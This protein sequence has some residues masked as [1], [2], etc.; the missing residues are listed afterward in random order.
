MGKPRRPVSR[1]IRKVSPLNGRRPRFLRGYEEPEVQRSTIQCTNSSVFVF[2]MRC[3]GKARLKR[4]LT[5]DVSSKETE[6]FFD[7]TRN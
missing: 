3:P 7:F 4:L 1:K 6:T 5:K 2:S